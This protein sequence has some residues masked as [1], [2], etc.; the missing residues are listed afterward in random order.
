VQKSKLVYPFSWLNFPAKVFFF[1]SWS[2][3]IIFFAKRVLKQ[4]HTMEKQKPQLSS[5]S[6]KTNK[7]LGLFVL[8]SFS[9]WLALLS[10]NTF[11]YFQPWYLAF[12]F[13]LHP[14]AEAE[15]SIRDY[16][17]MARFHSVHHF[18]WRFLLQ[19]TADS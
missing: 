5:P 8:L 2:L 15:T 16:S 14:S 12:F 17:I 18:I 6:P 1:F 13:C 11:P 7:R 9:L 4:S 10:V 19:P 3:V